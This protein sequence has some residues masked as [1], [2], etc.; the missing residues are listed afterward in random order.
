MAEHYSGKRESADFQKI[1]D[2]ARRIAPYIHRT[3]VMSCQTLNS[4]S[5][6]DLRFKCENFQK[7][8]AFKIRGAANAVF[9]LPDEVALKGVCTHSSGN[10]AQAVAMA[11]KQRGVPATIIMP[12]NASSVKRNGVL[13]YGGEVISC[14]PTLEAREKAANEVIERKGVEFIHPYNDSRVIAGQAT[15]A[16][17]LLEQTDSLDM[18]VAPVGGGGLLSGTALAVKHLMPQIKVIAAEPKGADDAYQSFQSGSFVPCVNPQTIAD[19]LRTSTG[20]LTLPIILEQV[21]DILTVTEEG[22]VRA[23]RLIWERMKIVVEPSG[24]VPFAAVLEHPETFAGRR[25]GLILSGGNVD[26]KQ[27]P[28]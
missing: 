26:L 25:V 24:A 13:G 6:A 9:S 16:L 20:S 10:H 12:E 3:P 11:A 17:E 4:I 23:M 19:G 27:L 18:I 28:F 8:G 7:M 15:V 22:I 2:A 1:R 14:E 5:G 21:D